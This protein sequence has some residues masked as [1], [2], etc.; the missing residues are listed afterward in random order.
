VVPEPELRRQQENE[1]AL[2]A[3][4]RGAPC[5]D[6]AAGVIKRAAER[7]MN[8]LA[9]QDPEGYELY[10]PECEQALVCSNSRALAG[11]IFKVRD[12]LAGQEALLLDVGIERANEQRGQVRAKVPLKA[13]Q[14]AWNQL[15]FGGLSDAERARRLEREGFGQ[16]TAILK[17]VQRARVRGV[18]FHRSE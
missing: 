17:R 4:F 16:A 1:R 9:I 6:H 10:W 11:L 8:L 12:R 15:A 13:F 14:E 18:D 3:I 2:R 5:D 7:A